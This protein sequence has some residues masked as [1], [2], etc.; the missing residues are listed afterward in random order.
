MN[1]ILGFS[2]LLVSQHFGPLNEAQREYA[3]IIKKSGE[4]LLRLM[5]NVLELSKI[6]AGQVSIA[7]EN[8]NVASAID[9]A[10]TTLRPLAEKYSVRIVE[11][12][13]GDEEVC[14]S[15]DPTRLTQILTNLGSNAI[16]YNKAGGSVAFSFDV[17]SDDVVRISVADEG[18]GIPMERQK[19]A[20]EPFNRLGAEQGPVEGTGI[21][22]SLI[23]SYV[24]LMGGTIGFESEEGEGSTFWVDLKPGVSES[25]DLALPEIGE[26]TAPCSVRTGTKVVY[27]E[28][29]EISRQLFRSY[30]ATIDGVELLDAPEGRAGLTLIREAHPDIV[31]LDLNLSGLNGF[32]V[33][34]ALKADPN[35]RT[36]PVVALTAS[37]MSGDMEAGLQMGFDRYLTKPVRLHE[38]QQMVT[39]L[40]AS[41]G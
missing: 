36:I 28:D 32:D 35:T 12:E 38:I 26:G 37:A 29:N 23:R 17:V 16:K 10:I 33:L 19:D 15:A 7:L 41:I 24:E 1:S 30:L 9:T 2:D 4:H 18:V 34:E 27:V 40:Q 31:F 21:G 8:V 3:N 22:L 14:V 20:F 13:S 5:D 39:E 6:E 25:P 11:S